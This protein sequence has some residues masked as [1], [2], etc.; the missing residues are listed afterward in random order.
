MRIAGF[1]LLAIAL[2]A[3]LPARA[4]PGT[5][6]EADREHYR[7]AFYHAKKNRWH[8]AVIHA[9]RADD[10]ALAGVI[11]WMRLKE[12]WRSG[13][14]DIRDFLESRP[15]WPSTN[16]LRE[17]AEAA[18]PADLDNAYVIAYFDAYPPLT[19]AGV[20]RHIEALLDAGREDDAGAAIAGAW[21]QHVFER[22]AERSF[23]G[24]YGDRLTGNQH[25]ERV[26]RL[27]WKGGT[28]AA[29]RILGHLVSDELRSLAEARL[30]MKDR[31]WGV[32]A[33]IARVPDH[34]QDDE[35]LLYERIDW[36]LDNDRPDG[37]H[38]LLTRIPEALLHPDSWAVERLRIAGHLLSKG[39][40]AGAYEVT[41][42]HRAFHGAFHHRTEWLAGWIALRRLDEPR[43]ALEHFS[44]LYY[45]VSLPISLARA[46]YWCG[47]ASEAANAETLAMDWYARAARHGQTF[48]GQL[49]AMRAGFDVRY[50]DAPDASGEAIAEHELGVVAHHLI[51]VGEKSLAQTFL[52]RVADN[53]TSGPQLRT[54]AEMAIGLGLPH[55]SVRA[56]KRAL[57]QG[58]VLVEAGHPVIDL[59]D[60]RGVDDDL[61]LAIINRES[62]F[63]RRAVSGRAALGLMQ[64]R[65]ETARSVAGRLG[66]ET[67]KGKLLENVQHN[68][69]LGAT[70]LR[71]LIREKSGSIVLALAAYNGGPGNVRKWV[72][73]LGNPDHPDVD[74]IDWIESIPF[75]ETRNYVQ[76]VIETM[77]VYRM[78]R[79]EQPVEMFSPTGSS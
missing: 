79:G 37:A 47:R 29:R 18:M 50:P 16:I 57:R 17:N 2:V 9:S 77:Q 76:R 6:N 65:L 78:L 51:D 26:D 22:S 56:A 31:E 67:S 55:V 8:D 28:A 23:L 11:H 13:F 5:L 41:A 27:I 52:L 15:D 68:I 70:Y 4:D 3:A 32:D 74:A 21:K 48:Y 40:A 49:A 75:H 10:Q 72:D 71:N 36:R 54:I 63:N 60:V 7:N 59:P 58:V 44:H 20:L 66:I 42:A 69:M 53:A 14:Y 43:T 1:A 73:R 38:D 62:E 25:W 39:D 24:N 35:A 30:L 34:L 61:V 45:E 64:I 33:A 19:D 12:D 46:A